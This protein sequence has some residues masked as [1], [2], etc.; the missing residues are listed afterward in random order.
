MKVKKVFVTANASLILLLLAACNALKPTPAPTQTPEVLPTTGIQY[1]FVTNKLLLPTTQ[2]Q[3]QAFALNVDADPQQHPDNKFGEMLTL[4]TSA[5]LGLELQSNLDQAINTGQLVLLHVVKADDPLN[6]P[7]ISW[8]I[9]LGQT[10]QAAPS[11]GGSDKFM[12]NPA[13]PTNT[14][15]VGALTNG[16]FTGGQG[17]ARIKIFLMGQPAEVDLIGVRL[18]TD[19]SAQGCVNGKLGGGVTVDEF[20]GKLLPAIAEGLN[21]IIKTDNAVANTLRQAFDS[22]QNGTITTQE[23][24][25]N[26]LLMFAISPDLDLLDASGKYSPGQDGVKDSY[27]VGLGFTCVPAAFTAPGD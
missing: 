19:L 15:I 20:R 9:F 16:H 14:P 21:Q 12:L 4:L 11:F 6:D 18:E 2:E 10:A 13:A 8:S 1:H 25:N 22:D 26:P 27:S 17:T 7:N 24:E 23:L 3:T 5:A